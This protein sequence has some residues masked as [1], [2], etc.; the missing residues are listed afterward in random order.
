MVLIGLYDGSFTEI[1]MIEGCTHIDSVFGVQDG[2]AFQ[3]VNPIWIQVLIF[4][5]S[6]FKLRESR[7][8]IITIFYLEVRKPHYLFPLALL[9]RPTLLHY[10]ENLT[11]L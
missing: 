3:E 1:G 6:L 9:G 7:L 2:H 4:S 5:L 8:N 10:L 11:N